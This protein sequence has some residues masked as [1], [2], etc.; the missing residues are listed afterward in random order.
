M[1]SVNQLTVQFG[2]FNLFKDI[3]FL[4]NPKDRIGLVGKNGAGKSTMLKI[5][6][7]MNP[8]SSGEVVIPDDARIGYLPQQMVHQDGK[9]VLEEAR[10]AFAEILVVDKRIHKINHALNQRDDYESQ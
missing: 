3:S 5:L 4:I 8:P 7:G 2:G 9:T 6:C 10:T 1:I